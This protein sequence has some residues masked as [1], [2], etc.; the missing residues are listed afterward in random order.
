MQFLFFSPLYRL[1]KS[2]NLNENL[3]GYF[4]YT[5]ER[6]EITLIKPKE[7]AQIQ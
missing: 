6:A 5:S 4:L 1:L 2:S 3:C 7:L